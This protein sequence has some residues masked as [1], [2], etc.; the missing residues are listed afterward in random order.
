MAPLYSVNVTAHAITS[1]R[2]M[3]LGPSNFHEWKDLVVVK[4]IKEPFFFATVEYVLETFTV[5]Q[6]CTT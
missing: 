4:A 1:N 5:H 2:N 6:H 3:I